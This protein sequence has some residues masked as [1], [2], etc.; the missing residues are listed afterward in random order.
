MFLSNHEEPVIDEPWEGQ[1]IDKE[2]D[3]LIGALRYPICVLSLAYISDEPIPPSDSAIGRPQV[4]EINK[5]RTQ[6]IDQREHSLPIRWFDVNRIDPTIQFNLMRGLWQG[7]IPI[8]GAGTNV[9]GEVPRSAMQQENFVFDRIA[10]SD[11]ADIWQVDHQ[12]VAMQTETK[13]E[14]QAIAKDRQIRLSRE[15]AKVG[16]F[17]LGIAEILGGLLAIYEDPASF[18]EG[19][20]PTISK[21]LAYSILADSTV[22]LDTNQRIQMLVDFINFTAKSGWL[23]LEPVLKELATLHGLDPALVIMKP[24]PKPPQEPN[25]SFRL[26]G[27]EDVMNPLTLA[28][29]IESGQAPKLETIETAKKLI[30]ASVVPEIPMPLP[31]GTPSDL[32]PGMPPPNVDLPSPPPPATGEANP[33]W[34]S[35]TRVNERTEGG[36]KQ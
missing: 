21:T 1:Q 34:T 2:S 29:L 19:F 24:E 22:L 12:S 26:T 20:S 4:D 17:F 27:T 15:R 18:G 9:I 31:D 28:F 5:G 30:E 32:P 7:M 6:M 10:K 11:L 3:S 16:K 33:A 36:G 25:I 13:A 8:Q 23:S 35:M 14:V